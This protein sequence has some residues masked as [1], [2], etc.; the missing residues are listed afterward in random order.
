MPGQY[1]T[2][3]ELRTYLGITAGSVAD[4]ALLNDLIF[5]ASKW[6]DNYCHRWFEARAGTRLYEI[7]DTEGHKLHLD[8]DLLS[9]LLVRNGDSS[10]TAFDTGDF[11]LL[12]LN[13]ERKRI[14]RLIWDNSWEQDSDYYISVQGNWGYSSEPDATIQECCKELAAYLYK[15]RDSQVFDVTAQ[16]DIGVITIPK[17]MP[18]SAAVKLAP[19]VR[20][21]VG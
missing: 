2:T 20:L 4:D 14:V 7:T 13:C 16:P 8:E 10:A 6:I 5:A 11:D 3:T 17:G 1:T 19:Y 21:A 9:V 15:L 12:P 18:Q